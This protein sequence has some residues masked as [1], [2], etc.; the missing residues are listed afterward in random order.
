MSKGKQV[1][2]TN[3][4]THILSGPV[5]ECLTKYF[6]RS[7]SNLYVRD[8]LMGCEVEWSSELTPP[9]VSAAQ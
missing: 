2:A 5:T 7:T 4:S 3:T 8:K 6:N 9:D 1:H